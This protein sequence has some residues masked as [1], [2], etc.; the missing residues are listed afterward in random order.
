[1]FTY[2]LPCA[3]SGPRLGLPYPKE[4]HRIEPDFSLIDY[5]LAHIRAKPDLVHEIVVVIVPGKELVADYV[6]RQMENVTSVK[7][8]YFNPKYSEWPGSIM[9][10]EE[11]FGEFNIAL[12][13]DSFLELKVGNVLASKYQDLFL[14]GADLAFSYIEETDVDRL[15]QLGALGIMGEEVLE[16][17]DK[18]AKDVAHKFNAFWSSFAFRGSVGKSVLETMMRSVAREPV[19]LKDIQVDVPACQTQNYTDLGTWPSIA[20][21]LDR[22]KGLD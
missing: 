2:I 7:S 6:K 20:K 4:I 21:F 15:T 14:A 10:A 3:G 5:S 19:S 12:L 17:C 9:S 16:F 22:K 11:C 18:P 13:P 1:L 8:V